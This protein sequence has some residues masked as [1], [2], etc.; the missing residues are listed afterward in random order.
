MEMLL[1]TLLAG[2][3]EGSQPST[4][5]PV[6][7]TAPEALVRQHLRRFHADPSAIEQA[8]VQCRDADETV[9]EARALCVALDRWTNLSRGT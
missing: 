5:P 3:L 2:L 6:P 7:I 8:V 4:L 1:I 9:S